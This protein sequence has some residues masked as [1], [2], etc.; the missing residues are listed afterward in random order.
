MISAGY[1]YKHLQN[2]I[3]STTFDLNNYQPPGGPLGNYLATQPVNAGSAWLSFD[4][5]LR[6]TDGNAVFER[7]A[8]L[9]V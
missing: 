2:P 8:T 4:D 5:I 6:V 1:F 3:I 9:T 7:N